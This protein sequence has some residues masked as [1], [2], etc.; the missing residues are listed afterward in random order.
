MRKR[1]PANVPG[2]FYVESE[3]CTLC[4]VPFVTAPSLFGQIPHADGYGECYVKKQPTSPSELDAM[5]ETIAAAELRC[6]RYAGSDLTIRRRLA[7]IG[8]GDVCDQPLD[9]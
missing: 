1:I 9:E 7:D 2:D 3:C 8:E 5:I 6:I 4:G